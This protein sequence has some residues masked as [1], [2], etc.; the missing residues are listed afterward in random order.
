MVC[1]IERGSIMS[2]H[3][4]PVKWLDLLGLVYAYFKYIL[5]QCN[6]YKY[7]YQKNG[8]EYFGENCSNLLHHFKVC[9]L[10]LSQVR[11]HP[12]SVVSFRWFRKKVET[13]RELPDA[14]SLVWLR[15]FIWP[16]WFALL[17]ASSA[18]QRN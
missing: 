12:I 6:F 18:N 9:W 14:L 10:S 5:L 7:N 11:G 4:P 8:S 3:R 13:G 16:I 2:Y 17:F 15:P 1:R